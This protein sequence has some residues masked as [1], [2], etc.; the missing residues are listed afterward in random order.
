MLVKPWWGM[1]AYR[2]ASSEH[3]LD[4]VVRR[5]KSVCT[6]PLPH[7]HLTC[8]FLPLFRTPPQEY[9]GAMRQECV[10][11]YPASKIVE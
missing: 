10:V 1:Q 6:Q 4:G 7:H 8:L 5:K 3:I 9:R 2:S 11:A